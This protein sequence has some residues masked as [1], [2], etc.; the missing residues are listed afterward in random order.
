M[1]QSRP[2]AATPGWV[3]HSSAMVPAEVTMVR[4]VKLRRMG[5]SVGATIPGD[6]ADRLHLEVGDTVLMIETEHGILLTPFDEDVV[7]GLAHARE[8]A[9]D[10]QSTLR[11][12][13]P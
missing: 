2:S 12:L 7:E 10:Y 9:R 3:Y 6:L 1:P 4:Q 11:R 13:A 5:G 8:G